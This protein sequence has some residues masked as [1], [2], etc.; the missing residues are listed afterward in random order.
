MGDSWRKRNCI[1]TKGTGLSL[2]WLSR[3]PTT[4]GALRA[5]K[6]MGDEEWDWSLTEQR[7]RGSWL[8]FA[9]GENLCF[10][11]TLFEV[12][13]T[14]WRVRQ[15]RSLTFC[16]SKGITHTRF[17][18]GE[19][20]NQNRWK[21]RRARSRKGITKARGSML[22]PRAEVPVSPE[23]ADGDL[24]HVSGSQRRRWCNIPWRGPA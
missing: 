23:K 6:G 9:Q 7:L 2:N 21:G 15:T 12:L 17:L 20:R 14:P 11:Q 4:T 18:Y 3:I 8:K 22:T 13:G 1:H 16:S 10:W 24:G 5:Q 19:K